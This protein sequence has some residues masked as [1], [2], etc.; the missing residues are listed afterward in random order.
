MESLTWSF[1]NFCI[2]TRPPL[3]YTYKDD[4]KS[5]YLSRLCQVH[6]WLLDFQHYWKAAKYLALVRGLIFIKLSADI[7]YYSFCCR[8]LITKLPCLQNQEVW[9]V[10]VMYNHHYPLHHHLDFTQLLW[11][12]QATGQI[13]HPCLVLKESQRLSIWAKVRLPWKSWEHKLGS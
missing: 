10:A 11:E 7:K 5:L 2:P 1:L 6:V 8:C 4:D 12:Q 3:M 9:L 13:P